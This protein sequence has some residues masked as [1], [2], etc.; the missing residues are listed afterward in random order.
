VDDHEILR[1]GIRF[2]LL[3]F[4]DIEL[5]GEARSGE[6]ALSLCGELEPDVVLMDM[7]MPELDGV[8]TTLAIRSQRPEVRVLVL[9]SYHD[10][11]QVQRAMQAGATGYL[12]KGVSATELAEAIRAAYHGRPA[13]GPEAVQALVERSGSPPSGLVKDLTEREQEVLVLLANGLTNAGIAAQLTVSVST[14]KY[15][16]RGIYSKLGA[17]NRAEATAL[18]LKHGLLPDQTKSAG[19]RFV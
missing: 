13:L 3:A 6:E 8:E 10:A 18:A 14:V 4:E 16:V 7:L 11:D 12:V 2:S 1:S 5:V 17:A 9:S 19:S 15:H